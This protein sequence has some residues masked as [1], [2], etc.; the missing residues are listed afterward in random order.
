MPPPWA[1]R[2][3]ANH[4]AT[5]SGARAHQ[6][7][8]RWRADI[9]KGLAPGIVRRGSPPARSRGSP[10]RVPLWFFLAFVLYVTTQILFGLKPARERPLARR[11]GPLRRGTLIGGLSGL[12][13]VGGA[14]ISVPFM[15]LW[16]VPFKAA[17]GTSAAISFVVRPRD[18]G[19]H[20]RGSPRCPLSRLD[21]GLRLPA[22]PPGHPSRASSSPPGPRL[23]HR[24]PVGLLKKAFAVFLLA[25]AVKLITAL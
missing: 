16:G 15:S 17:I 21:G 10:G 6:P 22:R 13:G 18:R 5:A 14:M 25:L 4:A 11:R 3:A 2:S 1:P 23:A 12:A 24:L 20:G 19:L 8:A 7:T 9:V